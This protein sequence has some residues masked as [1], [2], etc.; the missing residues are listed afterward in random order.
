[1]TKKLKKKILKSLKN[2]P[3]MIKPNTTKSVDK[4]KGK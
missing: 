1:M 4:W 2:K 3:S